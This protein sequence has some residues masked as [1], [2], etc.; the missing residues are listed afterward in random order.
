MNKLCPLLTIT[1]QHVGKQTYFCMREECAW[2]CEWTD[3]CAL[4]A[5][6]AEI[7]DRLSEIRQA[8]ER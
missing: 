8:G 7:S 5:I 1:P 2:W 4:V 6:P 3:C